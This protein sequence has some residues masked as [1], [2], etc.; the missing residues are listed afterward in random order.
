MIEVV[1]E[2]L[3]E[4]V[5]RIKKKLHYGNDTSITRGT[6]KWILEPL[7]PKRGITI[8]DGLGGVGKSWFAMDLAYSICTGK[9]FLEKFP[10]ANP[11]KVLYLTAEED[12]ETFVER[13]DM[14]QKHYPENKNFIWLSFLEEGVDITSYLCTKKRW[15]RVVTETA[16]IIEKLIKEI[17]PV[18]V[19]IDPL[20]SFFGLNENDSED[21]MFFYNVLRH[22]IREYHTNFLILHHQNKEGMKTQSDDVISFRG[23]GV[24]REQ[25]RSRIIYKNIKISENVFA[26]KIMLE[27]SNRHS[28]LKNSLPI[29]LKF[30]NGVHKYDKA[31]ELE[32]KKAEEA[33]KNKNKKKGKNKK[34]EEIEDYEIP[35]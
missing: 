14:V 35:F 2:T 17:E 10:V 31:F 11:G 25:A 5:E 8:L 12:E 26:K 13:L 6:N 32:A 19:V 28:N 4:K 20:I 3:E 24:L 16:Q 15:D 21:A 9:D 1:V 7:I 34:Q 18:L 33:A 27:K 23:S 29:Y 22:M 30:E